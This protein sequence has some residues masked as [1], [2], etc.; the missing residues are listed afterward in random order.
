M[1]FEEVFLIITLKHYLLIYFH[2]LV[3]VPGIGPSPIISGK[4]TGITGLAWINKLPV[5]KPE[6]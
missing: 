3:I 5:Q 6:K 4:A 1:N 2:L